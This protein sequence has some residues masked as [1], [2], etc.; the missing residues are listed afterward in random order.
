MLLFHNGRIEACCRSVRRLCYLRSTTLGAHQSIDLSC[1]RTLSV[2]SLGGRPTTLD[3]LPD[4]TYLPG[5]L[6]H[7]V[8]LRIFTP[9]GSTPS[10]DL[11]SPNVL[12]R[13]VRNNV[14]RWEDQRTG[15][16]FAC[17][18]ACIAVQ[19]SSDAILPQ[20]SS[21]VSPLRLFYPFLPSISSARPI[22]A[23]AK[24]WHI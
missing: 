13:K 10:V 6:P 18:P 4:T 22:S 17:I 2:T 24:I 8:A 12:P 16:R 11:R 9:Y 21:D 19:S 14:T 20:Y 23:Q 1:H 7:Y 3:L 5:L 15:K